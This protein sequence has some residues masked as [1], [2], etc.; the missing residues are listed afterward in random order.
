V[1]G[2]SKETMD[3]GCNESYP[4]YPNPGL[5]RKKVLPLLMSKLTLMPKLM[6][7]PLKLK[8]EE[9]LLEPQ[10]QRLTGL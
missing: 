2:G 6:R 3:D 5:G 9:A 4:L 1:G 8:I 7:L 10:C